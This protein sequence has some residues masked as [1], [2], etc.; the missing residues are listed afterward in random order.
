VVAAVVAAPAAGAGAGAA[1]E[2]MST[3]SMTWMTPLLHRISAFVTVAVLTF[4]VDPAIEIVTVVPCTVAGVIPLVRAE[5]LTV[6]FTTWYVRIAERSFLA[7]SCAL[8][9]PRVFSAAVKASSVGANTVKGPVPLRVATKAAFVRASASTVKVLAATAV[10]T[11]SFRVPA[12]GA[13]VGAGV[14]AGVG[15]AVAGGRSTLSMMWITPLLHITSAEVTVAVFTFTVLPLMA[16][17]T[18]AP[19]N[20]AGVIPFFRAVL[21]TDPLTTWYFKMAARSVLFKSCAL[22]IPR[23]VRAA[24]KAA[25][26]GAKTV[27]GPVPLRVVIN[28]ALVSASAKIVKFAA[29]AVSTMLVKFAPCTLEARRST[30]LKRTNCILPIRCNEKSQLL[31]M[32]EALNRSS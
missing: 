21:L 1:A 31:E 7:R 32:P 6:P 26:V 9:I 10:S 14:A 3:W 19:C 25:S 18:F 24:A 5:L 8:V 30:R 17:V 29:T 11:M 15:A 23:V 13:G 22:V 28:P 20:V 27:K 4:T 2:G 12:A 16:I